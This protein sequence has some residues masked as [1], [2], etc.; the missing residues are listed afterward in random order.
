MGLFGNIFKGIVK[1]EQGI[2]KPVM[3]VEHVA[4]HII[5]G[6]AKQ[7]VK[8]GKWGIKEAEYQAKKRYMTKDGHLR[9]DKVIGDIKTA[10]T[11]Y[12]TGGASLMMPSFGGGGSRP[13]N[14][15]PYKRRPY[16]K[17]TY[18][19]R[20]YKRKYKKRTYKKRYNKKRYYKKR[21][22]KKY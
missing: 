1:L 16:K 7:G 11:A 5:S 20:T 10:G 9:L 8:A 18:K 13:K 22:Y 21:Y 4:Q 3:K 15:Q 6:I 17:R 14:R 19:K 2:M 12:E